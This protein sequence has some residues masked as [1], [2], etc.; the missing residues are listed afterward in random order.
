MLSTRGVGGVVFRCTMVRSE[1]DAAGVFELAIRF[2][3]TTTSVPLLTDLLPRPA[4]DSSLRM[5][6]AGRW[7]P[8]PAVVR[9]PLS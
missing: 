3:M 6:S 8:L 7:R 9:C 2:E 5:L 4:D 1:T